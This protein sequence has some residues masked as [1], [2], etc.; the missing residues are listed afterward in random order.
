VE[1][2]EY[3]CKLMDAPGVRNLNKKPAF[4]EDPDHPC[5]HSY[6]SRKTDKSE[7]MRIMIEY[8]EKI[9][10]LSSQVMKLE[11]RL[12]FNEDENKRIKADIETQKEQCSD[13]LLKN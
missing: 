8:R 1:A 12:F 9:E 10:E 5:E 3:S 2:T 13:L 4:E 11:Q 7:Q 6:S